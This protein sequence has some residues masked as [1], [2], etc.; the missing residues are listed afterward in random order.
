MGI[1]KSHLSY[2]L[3]NDINFDIPVGKSGDCF[4]RYLVRVVKCVIVENIRAMI[5]QICLVIIN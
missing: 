5:D 2:E 3:Y 4:D 1:R